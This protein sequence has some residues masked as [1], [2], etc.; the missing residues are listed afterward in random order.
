MEQTSHDLHLFNNDLKRKK[1][2]IIGVPYQGFFPQE[3]R[4]LDEFSP[5]LPS[6]VANDLSPAKNSYRVK[7]AIIKII[8]S[9]R[10]IAIA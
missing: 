4:I 9:H 10:Q 8:S 1:S 6:S 2:W 3:Y 7:K 5:D